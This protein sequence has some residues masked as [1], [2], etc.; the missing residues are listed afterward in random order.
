M[1]RFY[2]HFQFCLFN[3]TLSN[4]ILPSLF[5]SRFAIVWFAIDFYSLSLR[6]FVRSCSRW[7]IVNISIQQTILLLMEY[8]KNFLSDSKR[9]ERI[10]PTLKTMRIRSIFSLC[11]AVAF[12]SLSLQP[13][14]IRTKPQKKKLTS[15]K[16]K[17]CRWSS[18]D[19]THH[20]ATKW[21]RKK[22]K[23]SEWKR[24]R[25]RINWKW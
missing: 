17:N 2:V 23:N 24:E 19:W 8:V 25:E 15:E 13:I 4:A 12:R 9:R 11:V 20:Y 10:F 21:S 1:F 16:E 6:S 5:L 18:F 7:K 3:E 22:V 14:I